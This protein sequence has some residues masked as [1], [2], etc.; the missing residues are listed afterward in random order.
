MTGSAKDSP[1]SDPLWRGDDLHTQSRRGLHAV[2]NLAAH[3]ERLAGHSSD[4]SRRLLQVT[5]D[6][7][8][9]RDLPSVTSIVRS[10]ARDLTGA[11]GVTF[12]LREGGQCLYADEEAIAPLWKGRRFPLETC[13]SGWVMLRG[14][15]AVIPDIYADSRIPHDAYRPTFVK[16]LVMVPVRT[17]DPVAAIGAYWASVHHASR[18]E[19]TTL[20]TLA[21]SAALALANVQLYDDLRTA[22]SRERQAREQAEA[23]TGA[24]DDFLQMIAH[25]LRQP[26]AA[27]AAAIAVMNARPNSDSAARGRDVVQRQVDHMTRLVDDLLDAARVVRGQVVLRKRTIDIRDVTQEAI[28]SIESLVAGKGHRLDVSQPSHPVPIE[29]DPDRLRQVLV[30]LLTNAAKYTN[31]CGRI[32]V[33]IAVQQERVAIHV[34]DTGQGLTRHELARIFDLFTRASSS[35]SGFGIGLAVARSLVRQ[36]GGT[37]EA[38]SE[39]PGRGSEFIVRLATAVSIAT[40]SA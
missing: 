27:C 2:E 19:L 18:E 39:G 34:K 35:E 30:N 12:V 9:A 36:H 21:E 16:S 8:F 20:E 24:K 6:L 7:A 33:H 31:P 23:A 29:G 17:P 5:R 14:T 15:P 26:L 22:L 10:A 32:S 11:D 28:D 38:R 1:G 25:E 37:L 40:E 13:I 4:T 3:R